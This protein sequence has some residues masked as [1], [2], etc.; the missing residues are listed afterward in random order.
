ML[1]IGFD[2]DMQKIAVRRVLH[3]VQMLQSRINRLPK[4][5]YGNDIAH[6]ERFLLVR[7]SAV[8][9]Y[10]I[11]YVFSYFSFAAVFWPH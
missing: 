4:S 7:L 3:K 10:S 11:R 9:Q 6:I 8:T 1:A 5:R 2:E